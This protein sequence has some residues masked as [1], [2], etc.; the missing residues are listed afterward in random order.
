MLLK[1]ECFQANFLLQA[2]LFLRISFVDLLL[3]QE[4]ENPQLESPTFLVLAGN[5]SLSGFGLDLM[6]I[7]LQSELSNAE[8]RGPL[9]AVVDRR[10]S[11]C[12]EMSLNQDM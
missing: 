12:T 10:L 1:L 5:K 11:I 3:I 7:N 2:A 6:S 8:S 9:R 4:R